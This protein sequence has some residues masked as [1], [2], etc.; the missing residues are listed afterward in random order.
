MYWAS[1]VWTTYSPSWCYGEDEATMDFV[2]NAPGSGEDANFSFVLPADGTYPQAD[3]YDT[4][5]LG[6]AVYDAPSLDHQAF[7]EFQFYPAPPADTGTGSGTE[8]CQSGGVFYPVFSAGSNEWFACAVVW[9]VTSSEN[10]AFSGPLDVQ[11]TTSILVLHS[12]DQIYVNETGVAQST[13]LPWQLA[14]TDATTHTSGSIS[15]QNGSVILSPYYST[16]AIG[17]VLRWG[18]DTPGAIAIAYEDGHSLNPAIPEGG[19]Y[20]GCYPGDGACDS[21]WPGRWAD[22]GQ[23]QMSLPILGAPGHQ[24]YPSE[25]GFG[26]PVEGEDWIN[27]TSAIRNDS[28]SC[29]APSWSTSTNCLYPWYTYRSQYYSFDFGANNQTNDTHAYGSLYQFPAEVPPNAVAFHPAPWGVLNSTVTPSFAQVEFNPIG[30]TNVVPVLANSSVYQEF[31]EGLYWLNVS[32]P[33]CP[34]QS[35]YVY[36]GAG[37]VYNTPIQLACPGLYDVTFTES[38]LPANTPWSV[39]LGPSTFKTRTPT[40]SFYVPNGTQPYSVESPVAGSAGIRY[41]AFLDNGSVSVTAA[42][43]SVNV[44]Y[45]LQYE[46]TAVA[47]PASA[48]ALIDPDLGWLLPGTPVQVTVV[49]FPSWEFASWTGIGNGSYSGP[50]NPATVIMN[51]PILETSFYVHLF[52]V[53]FTESGLPPNTGWGAEVNGKYNATGGPAISF[54]IAN[55]S[56]VY[57]ISGPPGYAITPQTGSGTINGG[58]ANVPVQFARVVL[59]GLTELELEIILVVTVAIVLA[60][61]INVVYWLTHRNRPPLPTPPSVPPPWLPPPPR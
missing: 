48:A 10:A 38:G 16:A 20:N 21:Y 24:T 19:H 25:I 22:S 5:W 40:V 58:N 33:G 39:T 60:V 7:L 53:S 52:V 44:A 9:Q 51:G 46:F 18:A 61:G 8:D 6:G 56:Y 3:F 45:T 49:P 4:V 23:M 50:A 59:F 55:G 15:L 54:E 30:R 42:P 57:N 27:G 31:M 1:W 32:Y 17:N 41:V 47:V 11:G 14:V 37:G 34:S 12:N 2:S 26:S 35:T 43:V 36:L 29:R 13:T 28:S